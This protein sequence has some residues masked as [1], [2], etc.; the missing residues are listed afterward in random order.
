[1]K[2]LLATVAASLALASPAALA[3]DVQVRLGGTVRISEAVEGSLN[4]AGGTILVNA[5]VEG[6]AQLAGGKVVVRDAVKGDLRAAGGKVTIDSTVGGDASVAAGTLILGP[7]A[8]IAGKLEFHGNDL[9]RD[10]AAVVTGA[11]EHTPGKSR[12]RYHVD[13]DDFGLVRHGISWAWT[14]G[15]LVLAALIAAALPGP[16]KRMALELRERPWLTTLV[17]LVALCTIPIAAAL[18]MVTII[19]IPLGLLAIVGYAA[20]LL[21]GYVWLAVVIGGLLLDRVKPETAA[22]TAWRAGAAA[23]AMLMLAL[24]TKIPLLGGLVVL[25]ALVVGVGMIVA[26]VMRRYETVPS[27][28]A[29]A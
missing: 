13:G 10:P 18:L 12:R 7:N 15:L 24:L 20:L 26:A 2:R 9:R 3:D 17:G 21:V 6:D 11:I 25:T 27:T 1:M 16:S 4:A 28:P 23:A 19:G 14:A 29:A 8:N 5:P 22:V